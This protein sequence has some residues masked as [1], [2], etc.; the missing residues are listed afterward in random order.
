M[1]LKEKNDT[2]H[3]PN[4]IIPAKIY[5]L[6]GD[7][8]PNT[9]SYINEKAP[10]F[11]CIFDLMSIEAKQRIIDD[12]LEAGNQKSIS[13]PQLSPKRIKEDKEKIIISQKDQKLEKLFKNRRGSDDNKEIKPQAFKLE[14]KSGLNRSQTIKK[15]PI[16]NTKKSFFAKEDGDEGSEW[17]SSEDSSGRN[18]S[19]F[20]PNDLNS[21]FLEKISET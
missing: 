4:L 3:Q 8:S 21:S 11:E 10:H 9:I 2:E 18:A 12:I 6:T 14:L 1:K 13:I 19:K 16:R 20:E 7:T 5:A 15:L 17:K